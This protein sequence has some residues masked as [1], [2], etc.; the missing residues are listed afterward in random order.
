MQT[1]RIMLRDSSIKWLMV[2]SLLSLASAANCSRA[3][4]QEGID[5][6]IAAQST[7]Q[8]QWLGNVLDIN[9]TYLEN[10]KIVDISDSTLSKSIRVDRSHSIYDF[11]QCATFT[12]LIATDPI[13]PWVIGAQIWHNSSKISKID[14]ILTTTDDWL[15]NSSHTLHYTLLEDWGEIPLMERDSRETIQAAGDAYLDVFKNTSLPVPWG[16]PC[17]RLEGGAYTGRGLSNDTCNVGIPPGFNY[18]NPN[19]RYVIDDSVGVVSILLEF[20]SI[21]NA[22][23]SHE[24]R[25]EKGKLRY[26]HT[27]TYCEKKPNCGY[28]RPP[29]DQDVGF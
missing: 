7:G 11:T 12:E 23:D 9:V 5:R 18:T 29:M 8:V 27:M 13:S 10:G 19:R 6:Y 22:P 14:R 28:D 15:F 3:L 2:S 1:M 20:G 4:L 25:V 26:I 24:F 17:V 16:S 21:G